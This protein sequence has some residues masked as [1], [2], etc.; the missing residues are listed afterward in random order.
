MPESLFERRRQKRLRKAELRLADAEDYL[1]TWGW[2][3]SPSEKDYYERRIEVLRRKVEK[4]RG[5]A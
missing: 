4:L 1:R 5:E 3:K 2:A